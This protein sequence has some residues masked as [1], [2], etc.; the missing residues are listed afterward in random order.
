MADGVMA[1]DLQD[2]FDDARSW[3]A[4][5]AAKATSERRVAYIIATIA[6]IIAFLAILLYLFFPLRNVEPYVIR[7]DQR[8]GNVDVVNVSDDVGQITSD[9]AVTKYFL[10]SYVRSRESWVFDAKEELFREAALLSSRKEQDDMLRER[11]PNNPES[12]INL[13]KSGETVGIRI[14]N[15]ALIDRRVAQVRYTRL[16]KTTLGTQATD[17]VATI[18]FYYS[19][20]PTTERARLYNPLGFQVVSYRK[21]PEIAQ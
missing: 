2:Y 5:R 19:E 1:K 3:D 13:Y 14:R 15:I 16:L 18:N 9:E 12:P 4:D 21:D 20:K 7:I 11:G 8:L 10:T 17:W 6:G